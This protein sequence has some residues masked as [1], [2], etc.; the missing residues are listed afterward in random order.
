VYPQRKV[1]RDERIFKVAVHDEVGVRQPDIFVVVDGVQKLV[2]TRVR[3]PQ[4]WIEPL[5]LQQK[6]DLIFLKQS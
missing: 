3:V 4:S 6:F 2:T 1:D 5:L